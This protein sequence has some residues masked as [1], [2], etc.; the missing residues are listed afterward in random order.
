MPGGRPRE[1]DPDVALDA[2][3]EVFREH[4]Y[5]GTSLAALT[6]A[7]GVN[8]PSLYAAFGDK[9]ALFEAVVERYSAGWSDDFELMN[10]GNS[11][12]EDMGAFVD[13]SVAAFTRPQRPK[14]CL[15]WTC[16]ACFGPQGP[17]P[18][19]ALARSHAQV[20]ARFR[21][22]FETAQREG[23]LPASEDL[24]ALTQFCVSQ[25]QGLSSLARSGTS[26]ERLRATARVG[27]RALSVS[28]PGLGGRGRSAPQP[29]S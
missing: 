3:V 4:G 21:S 19:S 11:L 29:H 17:E 26:R 9:D 23:D 20:C 7:M 13:R 5:A 27:I 22:R 16:M 6:G 18:G 25:L 28:S 1:F 15:V 24:E 2:A 10:S 8:R 14:G 12:R